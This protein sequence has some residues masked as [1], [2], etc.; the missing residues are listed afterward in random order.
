M[1]QFR[2]TLTFLYDSEESTADWA[3]D[4]PHEFVETKEQAIETAKAELENN[5]VEDFEF[6]V[7]EIE[8]DE[9]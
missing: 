4:M 8:D 3:G 9:V 6:D 7:E 1:A 2:V 5:S